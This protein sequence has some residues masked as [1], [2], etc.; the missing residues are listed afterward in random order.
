MTDDAGRQDA[1]TTVPNPERRPSR[2][3]FQGLGEMPPELEWFANLDNPRTR[4][5]YRLDVKEFTAFAGVERPEEMRQITRAHLIAWRKDLERRGLAP[6]SIRR[7]LAA[8]ASLFD[9]LC[10]VN[11]VRPNPLTFRWLIIRDL[12]S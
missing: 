8:V 6:S 5:A 2:A 9:H 4:R 7:K 12:A 11:A 10:E 1:L 3:E